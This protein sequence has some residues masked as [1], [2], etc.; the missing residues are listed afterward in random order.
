M[1]KY[2][3]LEKMPFDV[4]GERL[5]PSEMNMIEAI[6]NQ[7]GDTVTELCIAF[8]VT[9]GAIS[10]IVTKLASKGYVLKTKSV[11]YTKEI[12]LS[13]TEKGQEVYLKHERFHKEMDQSMAQLI[14]DISPEKLT[15]F[16]EILE[17]AGKH[18]DKYINLSQKK[19]L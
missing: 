8:G 6:G 2:N 12:E 19:I 11:T 5:Y 10:Q 4:S 7:T 18:L 1:N 9:K 13:L 3:K 15:A 14:H 16:R 17:L